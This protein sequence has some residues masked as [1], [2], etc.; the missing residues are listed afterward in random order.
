MTCLDEIINESK[1]VREVKRALSVKMVLQGVSPIQISNILN[2]SLQY[3]SKW[4]VK[5]ESEGA[6][7]LFISHKGSKGYLTK[8]Q[9]QEILQWVSQYETLKIEEIIAYI[10]QKYQVIYQ[11][12]QSYYDV[13]AQGGMSYHRSEPVNP[14]HNTERVLEKREEI[15]K[16]F[17]HIKSKLNREK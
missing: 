6:S 2:V 5:Y 15:K 13:L 1:D 11:S 7:S 10:E 16:N 3:V 14:K 8:E 4:K 17:W 9:K 12:K